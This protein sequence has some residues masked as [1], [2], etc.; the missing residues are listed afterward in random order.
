MRSVM[1]YAALVGVGV[2]LAVVVERIL[3][4]QLEAEIGFGLA[5][6][7]DLVPCHLALVRHLVSFSKTDLLCFLDL[8]LY[9]LR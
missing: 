5:D 4:L 3:L 1:V 7:F 8:L 6:L 2:L 9:H